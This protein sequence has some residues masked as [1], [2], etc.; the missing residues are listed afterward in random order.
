MNT[1]P[2]RKKNRLS[3]D[4]YRMPGAYFITICTQDRKNLF[5]SDSFLESFQDIPLTDLG[6]IAEKE[7]LSI[8]EG[9]GSMVRV[10]KYVVMPNHVHM[11]LIMESSEEHACPDIRFAVR[12]FKRSVSQQAGISIWQKGFHD[13]II[14]NDREYQEIWKYIDE[15]PIKW[16][17]DKYY[18]DDSLIKQTGD[19][20]IAP[21]P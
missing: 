13:H 9:Y 1:L 4:L 11:L 5:W 7:I 8:A 12:L 21:T 3:D 6:H 15:N 14:R 10:E 18:S 20:G 2:H 17:L 19:E 16:Q